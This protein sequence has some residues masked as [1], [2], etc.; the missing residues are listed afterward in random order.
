MATDLAII[1]TLERLV[2]ESVITAEEMQM[3]I[4]EYSK[5]ISEKAA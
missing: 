2:K 1:M 3:V 5:D 4:Q